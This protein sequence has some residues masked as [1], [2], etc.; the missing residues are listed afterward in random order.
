MQ[1]KIK[2]LNKEEREDLLKEAS[3]PI[4]I[5]TE[6]V[7]AIKSDLALSWNKLRIVRRY[8]L[9]NKHTHV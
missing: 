6:H 3:L 7:L 1:S 8:M 2:S 9:Y 4:K 5:P